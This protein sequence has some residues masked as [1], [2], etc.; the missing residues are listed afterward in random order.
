MCPR[1]P[2]TRARTHPGRRGVGT[3]GDSPTACPAVHSGADPVL[4]PQC[5]HLA[6]AR[7]CCHCPCVSCSWRR[8]A[9]AAAGPHP[10]S[11]PWRSSGPGFWSWPGTCGMPPSCAGTASCS[12][13]AALSRQDWRDGAPRAGAWQAGYWAAAGKAARGRG[14]GLENG[15]GKGPAAWPA[16]QRDSTVRSENPS[17]HSTGPWHTLWTPHLLSPAG[18]S[19]GTA[20]CGG[21]PSWPLQISGAAKP[22]RRLLWASGREGLLGLHLSLHPPPPPSD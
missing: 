13:D 19:L 18:A 4:S 7:P 5:P 15:H 16:S 22:S 14:R 11:R 21:D 10:W 8:W 20:P 3:A 9:C 6:A 2:Q 12:S 17:N 1:E